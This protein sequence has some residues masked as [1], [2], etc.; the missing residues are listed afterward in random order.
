ME[1]SSTDCEVNGPLFRV[2][3]LR[4]DHF[5]PVSIDLDVRECVFITGPSGSGKSLF[6]RGLVD[7]DP[8]A[9]EVWFDSKLREDYTPQ[10]WRRKVGLLPAESHWWGH[11]VG[12]H[13]PSH[14][15]NHLFAELGFEND[16]L[17]WSVTRLSSGERQRLALLRLLANQP[18]VLLLDEPTANLDKTNVG[19]VE[20]LINRY[21]EAK[22]ACVVWVSHSRSQARRVADR[23]IWFYDGRL[24][25]EER[26]G[27]D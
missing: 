14:N 6:L 21:V 12:E 10:Q 4:G 1:K 24:S 26:N 23:V 16:V 2:D 18:R 5:G 15:S 8:N 9:G 22:D 3:A 17:D 13:F 19:R 11:T 7:L 20:T 25:L 27:H